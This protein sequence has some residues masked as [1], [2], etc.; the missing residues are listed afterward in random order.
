MVP[1]A[2]LGGVRGVQMHPPLAASDV[3]LRTYLHESIKCLCSSGMQQQQPGTVAHSQISSLLISRRL[4]RPRVASKYSV[5]TANM[6]GSGRG[7]QKIFR[8]SSRTSSWNPP[9]WI[10]KS[11]TDSLTGHLWAVVCQCCDV[12]DVMGRLDVIDCVRSMMEHVRAIWND[13]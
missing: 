12:T 11:A 3:F 6:T 9:F 8:R 4:T 2:D 13:G 10:S 7:S 5:R 1:V